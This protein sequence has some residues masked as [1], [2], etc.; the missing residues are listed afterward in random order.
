MV[1]WDL[2]Q[3]TIDRFGNELVLIGSNDFLS[4]PSTFS[5]CISTPF[6]LITTPRNSTSLT[7]H[8]YF[9]GFTNR[10]FSSNL[11]ST[12]STNLSCPSSVS[13]ATR[14]SSINVTVSPWFM[15]SLNRSFII[16]WKVAGK[17]NPKFRLLEWSDCPYCHVKGNDSPP[18]GYTAGLNI[19]FSQ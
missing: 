16:V 7:F 8:L 6:G 13:M 3:L 12:S 5:F 11:F 9:S 10:S 4:T 18:I 2:L 17:L 15:R 1:P 19:G 14:I